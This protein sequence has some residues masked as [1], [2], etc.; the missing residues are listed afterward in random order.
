MGSTTGIG[1]FVKARG[2]EK[3][4]HFGAPRQRLF[5]ESSTRSEKWHVRIRGDLL[6]RAR[7]DD[8]NAVVR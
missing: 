4:Y 2:R 7:S 6:A 5:D 3:R 1:P 8:D